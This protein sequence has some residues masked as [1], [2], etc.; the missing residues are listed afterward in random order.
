MATI[1]T[2]EDLEIWKMA[3]SFSKSIFEITCTGQFARDF[4]L[5]DQINASAGSVMDNIAEGFERGGNREFV[6]F[7]SYAKGSLGESRSQLIRAF[8]RDYINEET[9]TT[10]KLEAIELGNRIGAFMSYLKKTEYKGSKF[11]EPTPFYETRN[12]KLGTRNPKP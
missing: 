8:D 11:H 10:F 3:R 4:S 2:F 6:N 9:L 12:P 5:R 7:L 1:K